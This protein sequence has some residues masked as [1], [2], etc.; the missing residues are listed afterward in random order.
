L[1]RLS[2]SLSKFRGRTD[3]PVV[4]ELSFGTE[5]APMDELVGMTTLRPTPKEA[6]AR[7]IISG[8]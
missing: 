8:Q 2:S 5:T 6:G 3:A 1:K 4:S 7:N